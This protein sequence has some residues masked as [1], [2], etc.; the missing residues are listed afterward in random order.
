MSE[1]RSTWSTHTLVEAWMPIASPVSAAFHQPVIHNYPLSGLTKD[2]GDLQVTDDDIGLVKDS[3]A[4]SLKGYAVIKNMDIIHSLLETYQPKSSF[5][6]RSCWNRPS[7][8]H[9]H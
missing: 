6:E 4:D 8:Q 9:L 3:Q 5:R 2:L 7:Q 1:D